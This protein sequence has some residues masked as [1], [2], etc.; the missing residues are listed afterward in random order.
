MEF[1]F[2]CAERSFQCFNNVFS[3]QTVAGSDI[4]EAVSGYRP[5][6]EMLPHKLGAPIVTHHDQ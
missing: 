5:V 3:G 2:S 6:E 4:D 1:T